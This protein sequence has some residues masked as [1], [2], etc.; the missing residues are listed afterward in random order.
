MLS[1]SA[2]ATGVGLDL[3]SLGDRERSPGREDASALLR[4]ADA[5]VGRTTDLDDARDHL[6][7]VLGAEAIAPAAAAAGNFEMMNRVVDATG[8]PAPRR[9]DQLAPQLGLRLVDGELLT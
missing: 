1:S 3:R 2:Q 6:T 8:I 7:D 5:L 4:F 9:M